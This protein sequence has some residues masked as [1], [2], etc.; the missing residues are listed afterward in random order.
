MKT[1]KQQIK[2]TPVELLEENSGYNPEEIVGTIVE[3]DGDSLIV[4]DGA[5]FVYHV[6]PSKNIIEYITNYKGVYGVYYDGKFFM[7]D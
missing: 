3:Y 5:T 2:E 4:E 7:Q 6:T 1:L